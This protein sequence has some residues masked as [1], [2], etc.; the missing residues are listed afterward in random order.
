[1]QTETKFVC[2]EK[3]C[4]LCKNSNVSETEDPC[5]ECLTTPANINSHK[6]INFEEKTK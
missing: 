2:Y 6:P 3:Y 1:M 5:N 4:P